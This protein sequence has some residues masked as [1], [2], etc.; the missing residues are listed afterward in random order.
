[1][2]FA[3]GSQTADFGCRHT[4]RRARPDESAD[5]ISIVLEAAA[6]AAAHDIAVW[7]PAEVRED[8]FAAAA[9]S[10]E[11]II[12][13]G[14]GTAAATMQLQLADSIYWPEA[15]PG[16]ALYIHKVAV[17]RAHAGQG[18]LA[19]LIDFA[20]ADAGARRIACLRLDTILQPKL[21]SLYERQGFTVLAEDPMLLNGRLMI[22]M[23]RTL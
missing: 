12:G 9:R 22:R 20:S 13:Y 11:L 14:N 18:W 2:S 23:E 21:Q 5:A 17:R 6:W 15:A 3:T 16:S 7:T 10:G 19:R 8:T 4:V 1:M